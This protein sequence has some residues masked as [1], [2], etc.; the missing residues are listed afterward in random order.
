MGNSGGYQRKGRGALILFH[1]NEC[2]SRR[3]ISNEVEGI[4]EQKGICAALKTWLLLSTLS[5]NAMC[6]ENRAL[7]WHTRREMKKL[8]KK[9]SGFFSGIMFLHQLSLKVL[10]SNE[11]AGAVN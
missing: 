5:R 3:C 10:L 4:G 2:K 1:L 6:E 9:K 8:K 11:C 7:Q